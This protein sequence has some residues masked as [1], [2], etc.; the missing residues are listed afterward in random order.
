LFLAVTLFI[1]NLDKDLEVKKLQKLFEKNG[2]AVADVRKAP[3]KR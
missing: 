2:L 3:N 1:A